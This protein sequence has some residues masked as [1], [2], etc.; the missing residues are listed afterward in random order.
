MPPNCVCH[1][2][3][4]R[5]CCKHC[6]HIISLGPYHLSM[7]SAPF[8]PVAVLGFS[9]FISTLHLPQVHLL[10]FIAVPLGPAPLLLLVVTHSIAWSVCTPCTYI[11]PMPSPGK[12]QLSLLGYSPGYMR[13]S[14]VIL[15]FPVVTASLIPFSPHPAC[16]QWSSD[17]QLHQ[18]ELGQGETVMNGE[19]GAYLGTKWK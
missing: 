4:A 1:S 5:L 9:S 10:P 15:M 13:L 18:E 6:G 19:K 8:A 12:L 3:Q 7:T 11:Y 16:A 2:V 17:S 14:L